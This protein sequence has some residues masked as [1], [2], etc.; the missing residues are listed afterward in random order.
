M[1]NQ[2]NSSSNKQKY[3]IVQDD[4][5]LVRDN[6]SQAIINRNTSDYLR[7]LATKSTLENKQA[8]INQLKADVDELKSLV[9]SILQSQSK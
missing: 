3:A 9:K 2:S 6:A 7:R 1:S 4:P 5:M 8:E